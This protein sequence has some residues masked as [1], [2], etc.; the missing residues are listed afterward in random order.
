M[1]TLEHIG[2][3]NYARNRDL[4]ITPERFAKI[5]DCDVSAFERRYQQQRAI[6]L[7]AAAARILGRAA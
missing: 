1:H 7:N 5:V 2:F 3:T 4:G 6:Q